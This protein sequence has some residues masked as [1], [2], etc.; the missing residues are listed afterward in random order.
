MLNSPN[1]AGF[2]VLA[3]HIEILPPLS[4]Q[5]ENFVRALW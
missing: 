2:L 3:A 1:R 5:E 4:I